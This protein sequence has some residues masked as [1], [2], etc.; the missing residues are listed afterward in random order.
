MVVIPSDSLGT[1]YNLTKDDKEPTQ[2]EGSSSLVDS[3]STTSRQS[4]HAQPITTWMIQS[5]TQ[6]YSPPKIY[7]YSPHQGLEMDTLHVTLQ[8]DDTSFLPKLKIAFGLAV[9]ATQTYL[10]PATD[11]IQLSCLIPLWALTQS[12]DKSVSLYVVV[13]EDQLQTVLDAWP[14]GYFTYASRKRSSTDIHYEL[15]MK[16]AKGQDPSSSYVLPN[17][18]YYEMPQYMPPTSSADAR[19]QHYF[20]EPGSSSQMVFPYRPS[21]TTDTFTYPPQ[22][23]NLSQPMTQMP[24]VL[25]HDLSPAHETFQQLSPAS[26]TAGPSM[27]APAPYASSS[28]ATSPIRPS[29]FPP[30]PPP[31]SAP[32]LEATSPD[33]FAQLISHADLVIEGNLAT[34]VEDW[35]DQEKLDNRRLV[36]FTRRQTEHQIICHCQALPPTNRPNT[37]QEIIVSCIYWPEKNDYFITSVD[38]IYLLEG[39]IGARFTTEEKNRVRRNLEGIKPLTVSKGK[40][41][42][43]DFFKMIMTF[44]HPKPRNIEKDLK[45]FPWST[46]PGALKKIIS[47]YTA[48]YSSTASVLPTST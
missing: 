27:L 4:L 3:A 41:D 22:D 10:D 47:K 43:A 25:A 32:S 44:N 30:M 14:F 16:R 18:P 15:A 1:K 31:P 7:E 33:P 2:E 11:M 24:S 34:M 17:Y 28:T 6:R 39:L 9:M 48:S 40:G 23:M 29:F 19:P 46:L 45:V 38:I 26:S 36:Q 13:Y 21:Q 42:N 8:M 37:P 12:A 20:E 5:P 35:T